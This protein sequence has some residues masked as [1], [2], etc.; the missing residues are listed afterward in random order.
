MADDYDIPHMAIPDSA[1]GAIYQPFGGNA[2]APMAAQLMYNAAGMPGQIQYRPDII[3]NMTPADAQMLQ[4]QQSAQ[5]E[6]MRK[7]M[8][9]SYRTSTMPA[10]MQGFAM[11]NPTISNML[12]G[13]NIQS[14]LQ[15]IGMSGHLIGGA[16]QSGALADTIA[17]AYAADLSANTFSNRGLFG[18]ETNT[19]F[20]KG[21]SAADVTNL[22]AALAQNG[23]AGRIAAATQDDSFLTAGERQMGDVGQMLDMLSTSRNIFGEQS[24]GEL[25]QQTQMFAGMDMEKLDPQQVQARMREFNEFNLALQDFTKTSSTAMLETMDTIQAA[26]ADP[27]ISSRMG[28]ASRGGVMGFAQ[29][30]TQQA[31]MS[32][33]NITDP[34]YIAEMGLDASRLQPTEANRQRF[35][36]ATVANASQFVQSSMGGAVDVLS[37][38]EMNGDIHAG[39]VDD[40]RE[41][42]AKGASREELTE[43]YLKAGAASDMSPERLKQLA[44]SGEERTRLKQG[45]RLAMNDPGQAGVALTERVRMKVNQ[46][47]RQRAIREGIDLKDPDAWREVESRML[48]EDASADAVFAAMEQMGIKNQFDVMNEQGV[49]EQRERAVTASGRRAAELNAGTGMRSRLDDDEQMDVINKV[50]GTGGFD[51]DLKA[52]VE[53]MQA[54]GMSASEIRKFMGTSGS[55]RAALREL[56]ARTEQAKLAK[57]IESMEAAGGTAQAVSR[58][59]SFGVLDKDKARE[60]RK[61]MR[62]GKHEEARKLMDEAVA[63]APPETAEQAQKIIDQ[64]DTDAADRLAGTK[65]AMGEIDESIEAGTEM[66]WD[67][68]TETYQPVPINAITGGKNSP[69]ASS[70]LGSIDAQDRYAGYVEGSEG[71]ANA[72][73]DGYT[74]GQR[75]A[76]AQDETRAPYKDAARQS[77]ATRVDSRTPRERLLSAE[78]ALGISKDLMTFNTLGLAYKGLELFNFDTSGLPDPIDSVTRWGAEK[79]TAFIKGDGGDQANPITGQPGQGGGGSQQISG[80]LVVEMNNQEYAATMEGE[81]SSQQVANA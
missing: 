9:D 24:I 32:Y 69:D 31:A 48:S 56:S 26:M 71:R 38:L 41:L 36:R 18:M 65:K 37:M 75:G 34:Q 21:F 6:E 22:G 15:Q 78:G 72:Q 74:V 7:A 81:T 58:L 55:G 47:V 11:S 3:P 17:M 16:N 44:V 39:T 79:M 66:V 30:A 43:F 73:M 8:L 61:L 51:S 68:S 42:A 33:L 77:E 60:I 80:R 76:F 53:S 13:G 4:L 28:I 52:Q 67:P 49:T 70:S 64:A 57:S 14:P 40:F 45:F 29:E 63:A 59:T 20:T 62:A 1:E 27:R 10:M 19:D 12:Y 5:M 2:I 54:R 23:R 46:E 50:I 25:A 35:E